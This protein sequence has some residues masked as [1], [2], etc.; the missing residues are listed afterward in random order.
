M[1]T[2][3]KNQ[4]N[5]LLRKNIVYQR[6]NIW[7]NC[8]L[9]SAPILFCLLLLAIRL[10]VNNLLLDGEDFKCGCQCLNCC[11]PDPK[12][13]DGRTN[14]TSLSSGTCEE[15]K[16][17]FDGPDVP[18]R[19]GIEFSSVEQ[20][21]WCPIENPSVWSPF[22]QVPQEENR[23][24]PWR[25]DAAILYTGTDTPRADALTQ[26]VLPEPSIT[27][28]SL[29]QVST[30]LQEW[31]AT[32]GNSSFSVPGEVFSFLGL[33][34]GTDAEPGQNLY[35]ERGLFEDDQ[36]VMVPGDYCATLSLND[37]KNIPLAD[38]VTAII[39]KSNPPAVANTMV[40]LLGGLFGGG[41]GN[42]SS[43]AGL[44]QLGALRFNC[45][46]TQFGYKTL[47]NQMKDSFFC[48]YY[49][50]KCEGRSTTNQLVAGYDWKDTSEVKFN[51]DIY[52]NDTFAL[53]NA[54][55]RPGLQ[56]VARLL[57]Q[58]A[59][60]WVKTFVG[61]DLSASLVGIGDT[62]KGPTKL[63]LDF[64]AL[65]GPL[66]YTWVVQ[67][68]FPVILMQLVYEKE[69]RLR[70]MMKMHGLSD[71]AYWLVMYSWYLLL[72]V[73]YI[74]VFMVFGSGINL[75]LFTKNAYGIQIIFYFLFGNT[76]IAFSFLLSSL[77]T[78]ARTATVFAFLVVFG[79]GLIGYLLLD[80][81][82]TKDVWYNVLI[83]LVPPFALF[84]ALWEFGEYAFL[85]SYRNTRGMTFA[86][87]SDSS[88]G[89]IT[90]WIILVVEWFV[91]M[92]LAWYLEQV[93]SSGTGMH[94]HPLYF[95]K[96]R[97]KAKVAV[98]MTRQ[99][100]TRSTPH[101]VVEAKDEAVDVAEERTRVESLGSDLQGYPIVVKGLKKTYPAQDGAPP[102]VA[103]RSL[104]L[105][106]ETGECFGLLGPNG[107]GKST[108]INMMVGFLEPT[109]GTAFVEGKDI[110]TDMD[111]IYERMGMCP[112]HDL[113]W[114][115]LTGAEHLLF[116]GRLKGLLGAELQQAVETGLRGVNLWNNGV[117]NK[118]SQQYSGG[119]KRRLSVAI[120]FMGSPGVVYL[121]EPSTGL[122]PA[123]RRQLWQVVKKNKKD[124]AIILTTHSMEEA[125]IL[126]DRL[127]IFV[128]G[129]LVCIGNPKEIASR[130]GSYYVFTITVPPQNEAKVQ[131]LVKWLS[132]S[133]K[134]T[135]AL[136]GTFKFELS[137][138]ET[139]LARVFNAV[140]EQKRNLGVLD[141][142]VANAT[143]EEVFIKFARS[144][145][146]STAE[147][148]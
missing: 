65:L 19:C 144:I 105:A 24:A 110:R 49:Q 64:S 120:S 89:M 133:Y 111:S 129:R 26:K 3:F 146:A 15:P 118:L 83:E 138:E 77:F 132:P 56:R 92:G 124:R 95:L 55:P 107:A 7:S 63:V 106:V 44:G 29:Q 48:G 103:V 109:A 10:L 34:I 73:V 115:T 62:P 97:N 60:S 137:S 31:N 40:Q 104:D 13:P 16:K 122:D 4:A 33:E 51:V 32:F 43:T 125:E 98:E 127:G 121:D 42:A 123:S 96:R 108:S 41:A 91:F 53:L 136:G 37:T 86:D 143:L 45:T 78:S 39:R 79:S 18:K 102:K 70:L 27:P 59:Q 76:L 126:C 47:V 113:L 21:V 87:L 67:M 93:V 66:F 84:R 28:K 116:Y 101:V 140:Q 2:T 142:G 147:G 1:G 20:A 71:G 12:S 141:W 46:D 52:F 117:G 130:Y 38:V 131:A 94:K 58:A 119:M 61:S 75:S 23:A 14:C 17:C 50:A 72:Y 128:D 25:P 11:T 36:Y 5:A 90:V 57:N 148:H 22:W 100:R 139:T 114:E 69:K 88:N 35:L 134:L 112:Q 99:D 54:G 74:T 145:N 81:L 80:R 85:A 30:Y 8:C 6:R 9:I 68:L 82:F 135:Y